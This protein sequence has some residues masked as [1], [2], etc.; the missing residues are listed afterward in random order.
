MNVI[1]RRDE[2]P[3]HKI[4]RLYRPSTASNGFPFD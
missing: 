1:R 3:F 4:D 2:L